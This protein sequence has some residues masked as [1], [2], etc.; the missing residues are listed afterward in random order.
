MSGTNFAREFRLYENLFTNT[1]NPLKEA[2]YDH[3]VENL[4]KDIELFMI[5]SPNSK[6]IEVLAKIVVESMEDGYKEVDD[7]TDL[8]NYKTAIT[9]ATG[10]GIYIVRQEDLV[11]ANRLNKLATR[12]YIESNSYAGFEY[13]THLLTLIEIPCQYYLDEEN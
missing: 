8:S 6:P 4:K 5:N 11:K 1:S 13:L 12:C 2:L 9:D 7:E 10:N 3:N